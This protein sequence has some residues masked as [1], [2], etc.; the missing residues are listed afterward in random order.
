MADVA[1]LTGGTGFVG[2]NL[3]RLLLKEGFQVRALTRKGANRKNL[4]GLPVELVEGDLL[5]NAA[6]ARGC[7]G[8]RYAFH[9][10]ADYRLWVRNPAD[11]YAANVDGSVNVVEA[12]AAAGCERIVHC[13]SVAVLRPP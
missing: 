6:L 4:E 9:V 2:A 13:S 3:A 1:F 5:D 10:A 7:Q 11:M 12:A 8:A